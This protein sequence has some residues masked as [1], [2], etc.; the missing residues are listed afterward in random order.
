M[1]WAPARKKG[2]SLEISFAGSIIISRKRPLCD[3]PD[4][5][6]SLQFESSSVS[7]LPDLARRTLFLRR[8]LKPLLEVLR[9]NDVIYRWGFPFALYAHKGD[10]SA[11]FRKL[12][13]LP[14]MLST[15]GLPMLDLPEWPRPHTLLDPPRFETWQTVSTKKRR[16]N[17]SSPSKDSTSSAAVT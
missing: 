16:P 17:S 12:G 15:F 3:L 10:R 7:L 4:P 11:T 5:P 13:D 14:N 8:A 1:P 2:T 6:A 9:A